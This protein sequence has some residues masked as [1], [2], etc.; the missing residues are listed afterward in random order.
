MHPDGGRERR[1]LA[2]LIRQARLAARTESGRRMTQQELGGLIGYSQGNVNKI[3]SGQVKIEPETVER[4]VRGLDIAPDTALRMRNLAR[5]NAVGIPFSRQR[6]RVPEY[7]RKYIDHEPDAVEILSWHELRLPGPL[8]SEHFMLR[9]FAATGSVDVAPLIRSRRSR[10]D[11]FRQRGLRR[12]ACVIA[13]EALHRAERAFGSGVVCD[14]ID[15]LLAINDPHDARVADERTSIRLLPTTVGM[16]H[17]Y[18]DFSILRL[19]DPKD[20]FVYVEHVAGAHYVKATRHLTKAAQ[21][22]DEVHDAALDRDHTNEFLR[23]LRYGFA[24]G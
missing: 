1:E 12:Y 14:E 17:L 9:Q 8:Q 22:W 15:Y 19:P 23:K 10:R 5:W 7:A 4:I 16:P 20:S 21:A 2:A 18:G 24:S 13:E 6:A 11:L 3:E